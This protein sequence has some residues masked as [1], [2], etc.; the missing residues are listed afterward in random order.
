MSLPMRFLVRILAMLMLLAAAAPLVFLAFRWNADVYQ[1]QVLSAILAG[2]AVGIALG[3]YRLVVHPIAIQV[4]AQWRH[5]GA[6][7]P[8][9]GA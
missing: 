8:D 7:H 4:D 1:S 5:R 3:I 6:R 9:G 2:A